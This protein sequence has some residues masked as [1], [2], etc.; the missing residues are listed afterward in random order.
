MLTRFEI[1]LARVTFVSQ[2]CT[3]ISQTCESVSVG[4]QTLFGGLL[5]CVS[6][7]GFRCAEDHTIALQEV[8]GVRSQFFIGRAA[9]SNDGLGKRHLVDTT[10]R[11][12]Y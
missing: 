12:L 4:I 7:D 1:L 5:C 2:Y 8:L 9:D 11:C 6:N 3:A 10:D